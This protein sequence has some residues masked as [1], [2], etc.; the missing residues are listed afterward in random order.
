R[1]MN[2]V[3]DDNETTTRRVGTC[4]VCDTP[5]HPVR[6]QA[7]CSP[8]CKQIAWRERRRP[9]PN[10]SPLARARDH[11]IYQCIDCETRYLAQQ[12]CTDCTRPCRSLGPGGPCPHCGD[13]LT[14]EE[15]LTG[16]AVS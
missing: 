4:P 12:W 5:F 10:P 16:E 7:Y 1:T 2:P 3:R 14:V 9:D 11:T 8:A 15:L 13:L 6:R